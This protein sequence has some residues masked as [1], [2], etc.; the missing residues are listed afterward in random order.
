MEC[1][2]DV[3]EQTIKTILPTVS[4]Y[5][6]DNDSY[7][8]DIAVSILI[9]CAKRQAIG[10]SMVNDCYKTL[11]N[12]TKGNN[13][14]EIFA[15]R[16]MEFTE[17][18]AQIAKNDVVEMITDIKNHLY[19]KANLYL[20]GAMYSVTN[21]DVNK[22]NEFICKMKTQY[23]SKVE[24]SAEYYKTIVYIYTIG[25]MALKGKVEKD[26]VYQTFIEY[27]KIE[28]D[29]IRQ[30]T[31]FALGSIPNV[32][33][34]L[35]EQLKKEKTH[36]LMNAMKE[37]VKYIKKEEVE[38]VMNQLLTIPPEE[39]YIVPLSETFGRLIAYD[40]NIYVKKYYLPT[41]E[42]KEGNAAL[43]GSIKGCMSACDPKLFIPLIPK[44]VKKLDLKLPEVK[45]ALFSITTYLLL[46]AKKD[47]A[48]YVSIIIQHLLPQT[49][50]DEKYVKKASFCKIE[51]IIDSGLDAR[52]AVFDCLSALIEGYLGELNY[53]TIVDTLFNSI[54]KENDHDLKLLCF[55]LLTRMAVINSNIMVENIENY[56]DRLRSFIKDSL[57]D[58]SK[59]AETPKQQEI[60]KAVCRFV[61]RVSTHKYAVVANKFGML[62]NDIANSAKLGALYKSLIPKGEGH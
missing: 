53:I 22:I 9:C 23:K 56:T 10:K 3:K 6:Y 58:K 37:A 38:N 49:V 51:H 57:D 40:A 31:S 35:F 25:F 39:K 19:T 2:G 61:G 28:N 32:I 29:A 5:I 20:T 7:I 11:V 60:S 59:D 44:I 41:L 50:V 4:A 54:E 21:P 15:Q 42:E 12:I 47:I 24:Q 30:A 17:V 1:R 34:S 27:L 18:M 52:K 16:F 14:R 55:N 36:S 33:P 62:M 13:A 8:V 26:L 46:N 43:I 45:G 48:P